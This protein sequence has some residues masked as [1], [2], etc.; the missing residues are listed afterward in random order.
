MNERDIP[1]GWKL[2]HVNEGFDGLMAALERADV[3]GYMP[4]A[5]MERWNGFDWHPATIS[6][7]PE[8]APVPDL[9]PLTC[10][11]STRSDCAL[12]DGGK[13]PSR[14]WYAAKIKETEGLD[15]ALP[16]GGALQDCPHAAPFRFCE[17]CKVSPCPIGLD[18]AISQGSD[19]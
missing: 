4:D 5:I 1:K 8:V 14:E 7:A 10:A 17:K 12:F 16:C 2:M 6:P 18:A 15:D 3:K 19:A 9:P 11:R 13:R